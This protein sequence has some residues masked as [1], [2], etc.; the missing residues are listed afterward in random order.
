MNGLLS[1]RDVSERKASSGNGSMGMAAWSD[2]TLLA[3]F[4]DHGD[5]SAFEE[6]VHRYERE[7][8]G[9]LRNYLGDADLAEDVFQQTFLRVYLK[10][11]QF[12]NDRKFRP[13]LYAVATNQAI[14]SR[15]RTVRQRMASL[16]RQISGED[17]SAG[18]SFGDLFGDSCD[19]PAE[20]S[21]LLEQRAAI[22]DAVDELP[23]QTRQVVLLV[24]FQGLKYREAAEVL[25]VPVGT[26]KSRLHGAIQKL[27]EVFVESVD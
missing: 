22:R 15:R 1:E 17:E 5:R 2:E 4:C 10:S 16:D 18:G 13:W 11:D 20:E 8:F 3:E 23:E 14:D 25:G 21:E 26:V 9:Y 24:Y 7:L 19:T 27:S 6:L 12:A